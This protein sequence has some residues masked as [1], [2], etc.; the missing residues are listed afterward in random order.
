MLC[1]T[2]LSQEQSLSETIQEALGVY[3]CTKSLWTESLS[4]LELEI[5]SSADDVSA[6]SYQSWSNRKA[7]AISTQ[8]IK[9]FITK[10][11]NE[12]IIMT[13]NGQLHINMTH[14]R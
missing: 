9:S 4:I 5:K 8:F 12:D 13:Y 3:T 1:Q 7:H 6:L 2:Q 11:W 10:L 14:N